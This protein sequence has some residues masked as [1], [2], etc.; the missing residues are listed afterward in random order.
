MTGTAPAPARPLSR[1]AVLGI[2]AVLVVVFAAI[3]YW[4]HADELTPAGVVSTAWPFLL[5]LLGAHGVL[6]AAG[7]RADEILSGLLVW[8]ITVAAGM[9]IRKV[10]GDGTA[11]PFIVVATLFNAATLLGWRLIARYARR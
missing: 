9:V 11:T 2:D 3:G 6:L 5:A 7:R 10:S 1:A 8:V 4:T